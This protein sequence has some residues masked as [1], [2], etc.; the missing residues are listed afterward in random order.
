MLD[1]LKDEIH[2]VID[3]RRNGI[4]DEAPDETFGRYKPMLT[5]TPA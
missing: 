1:A 2:Q 4:V 3:E 5:L